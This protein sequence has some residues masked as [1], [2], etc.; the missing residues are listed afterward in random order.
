MLHFRLLV[1]CFGVSL[2]ACAQPNTAEPTPEELRE[3]QLA[4]IDRLEE[5][6]FPDGL[7]AGTDTARGRP[8]VRAVQRFAEANQQDIRTPELL[9][10]A[11]GVASGIDWANKSIQL[12]GYVWRWHPD[13]QRAPEAMFYQGFVMDTRYQDYPLAVEY[14]DRFLATYPEHELADQVRQLR[15]VA[16]RGGELP[17]V[18]SPTD[19]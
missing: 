11:A 3:Q 12:W 17:K 1:F 9:M 7:E 18:P 14:Y 4:E 15:D 16:R 10:K 6:L 8:F 13:Y 2:M 19:N 5:A